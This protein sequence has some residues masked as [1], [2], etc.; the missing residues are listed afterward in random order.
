MGA[1]SDCPVE[2]H[3]EIHELVPTKDDI[4]IGGIKY[5][6]CKEELFRI[7]PVDFSSWLDWTPE[8]IFGDV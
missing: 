7:E 8:H 6:D 2:R 4:E 1:S 3:D 5:G